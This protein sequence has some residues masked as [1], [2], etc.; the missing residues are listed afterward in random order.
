V[1]LYSVRLQYL[2]YHA[3]KFFPVNCSCLLCVKLLSALG[4][5]RN[6]VC[7]CSYVC[8]CVYVRVVFADTHMCVCVNKF[9]YVIKTCCNELSLFDF[10]D[11][12]RSEYWWVRYAV[13]CESHYVLLLLQVRTYPRLNVAPWVNFRNVCSS[14]RFVSSHVGIRQRYCEVRKWGDGKAG[15]ER[16]KAVHSL[17]AVFLSVF[18]SFFPSTSLTTT[19]LLSFHCSLNCFYFPN[20]FILFLSILCL[21]SSLFRFP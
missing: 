6:Y 2:S 16:G 14:T 5:A 12:R 9:L 18:L 7:V 1:E 21:C 15:V 19:F 10:V 8:V 4:G 17:L 3:R 11:I 13:R 20:F